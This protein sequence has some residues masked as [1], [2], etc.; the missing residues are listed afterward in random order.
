M[1]ED[2]KSHGGFLH[3]AR[4]TVEA[5]YRQPPAMGLGIGGMQPDSV[6]ASRNYLASREV[7]VALQM[8][9][10]HSDHPKAD[11]HPA[12]RGA[13]SGLL[14]LVRTARCK[15]LSRTEMVSQLATRC[16]SWTWSPPCWRISLVLSQSCFF[17]PLYAY[18]DHRCG[19]RV[20]ISLGAESDC[21]VDGSA[22]SNLAKENIIAILH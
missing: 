13:E 10:P 8:T 15:P 6:L 12:R 9:E 18:P 7:G 20:A 16:G 19:V 22:K 14:G 4:Q 21:H 11:R 3:K 17:S 1:C 5:F 2:I